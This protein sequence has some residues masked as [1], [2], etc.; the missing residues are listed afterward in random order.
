MPDCCRAI[1]ERLLESLRLRGFGAVNSEPEEVLLGDVLCGEGVWR[2][3][4]GEVDWSS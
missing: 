3:F 4:L 2:P 1:A